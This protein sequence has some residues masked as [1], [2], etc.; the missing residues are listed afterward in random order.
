[1]KGKICHL[2]SAHEYDDSRIFWK[3]CR[4]A[5][6]A[7][8]E[9]HLI[10]P[11]APIEMKEG[12]HLHGL[13]SPI[14]HRLR[15]MTAVVQ[16][17][18]QLARNL[19]VDLYHFHDPEL[20]PV[21]LLLKLQKKKVIYDVH[22]D[23]PQAVIDKEWLP[24]CTRSWVAQ[25]TASLEKFVA[26]RMDL[27][28]VVTSHIQDRFLNMGCKT[29]VIHNYPLLNEFFSP[30]LDWGKKERAVCYAGGINEIRGFFEMVAG[31]GMTEGKLL[32]AGW[33]ESPSDREKARALAGWQ[34]VEDLGMISRK[35]VGEIYGKSIAGLV[36]YHPAGNHVKALPA[37]MFEYMAAGIPVICSNFPLWQEIVTDNQ[38]GICVDP[39]NSGE[40]AAAIRY[41]LDHPEEAQSIG[42]NGR[43]AIL[44]KYN[45]ETESKK[46]LTMY[47]TLLN[48]H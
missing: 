35:K 39:L 30:E 34:Q 17:V 19:N 25:L 36:L 6:E 47:E 4:A 28:V 13:G 8:F 12:V 3:E 44:E 37:K 40:I 7:G 29:G 43:R 18:Y 23:Y 11:D 5:A 1:M 42:K 48:Q 2:T 33:F 41:L 46:L 10:A 31:I 22:E 27:S 16:W 38:C 14:P 26:R 20:L 9:T 24:K 32:L 45:W 21:G 15:R